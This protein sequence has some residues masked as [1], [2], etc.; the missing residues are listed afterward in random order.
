MTGVDKPDILF[1]AWDGTVFAHVPGNL[2]LK[3][4]PPLGWKES[5]SLSRR[6]TFIRMTINESFNKGE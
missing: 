5:L 6:N 2:V 4:I 1:H 3:N